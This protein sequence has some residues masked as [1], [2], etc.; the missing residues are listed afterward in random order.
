MKQHRNFVSG[1]L[2]TLLSIVYVT[3]ASAQA[4]SFKVGVLTPGINFTPVFDGLR[5]G[6]ERLGYKEGANVTF[7]IE[8]TKYIYP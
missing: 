4:S 8:D 5:E 3:M 6:L 7:I 1:V 2:A